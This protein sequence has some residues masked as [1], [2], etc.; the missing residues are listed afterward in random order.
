[1][2]EIKITEIE[3]IQIGHAQNLQA[4]TGCTVIIAKQGAVAGVDVKGGAPSTRETDLLSPQN[5]VEKI[6]AVT[7]SGG[8]AF[9]LD[10]SA[11]VMKYLEEKEIGFDVQ[12]TKVPIVCAASLF[13]LTFG[14]HEV[15]PDK[16][17]G[18]EACL[19]SEDNEVEQGNVGAGCGATVGK[20]LGLD[21]AMKG[22]LGTYALQV[23]AVK[24]GAVVAV[25]CLGDVIDYKTGNI[26]AGVL[27]ET[28]TE[29][30]DTSKIMLDNIEQKKNLFSGNT[31]IGTIITNAKLTKSKANKIA[32]IAQNGY[33]KTIRPAH[34]IF[35]GDTI[36]V[37]STG[38]VEADISTIGMLATDVLA[39]A[40]IS[41]IKNTDSL[42]GVLSYK[43][44]NRNN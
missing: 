12:V 31:T 24:I 19:N 1:M 40:L 7:L 11:G 13:D 42:Y 34:T 30:I 35:D 37:M 27:N 32:S 22:G 23:G 21:R 25:N 39:K 10:A 18:Y 26:L 6:H 20:I 2:K 14:D 28:H 4:A 33:A 16:N 44:F 36:F 8:S 9:G 17:M 3:D 41:A 43:E 15:R 5:L 29:F 38:K